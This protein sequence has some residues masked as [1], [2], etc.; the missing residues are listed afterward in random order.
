MGLELNNPRNCYKQ[1]FKE[2]FIDD[3]ETWNEILASRNTTAHI[4]SEEDYENI[5]GKIMNN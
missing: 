1:A 3:M 5:K 2:E 4:Y